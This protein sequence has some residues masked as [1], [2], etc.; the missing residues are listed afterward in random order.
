[1]AKA[2]GDAGGDRTPVTVVLPDGDRFGVSLT[3]DELSELRTRG[4]AA[5]STF[6]L[7]ASHLLRPAGFLLAAAVTA[8]LIPAIT[9]QW[10]DRP[11]ETELKSSLVTKAGEAAAVAVSNVRFLSSGGTPGA[12]AAS[13]ACAP[14]RTH[15]RA[16]RERCDELSLKRDF[17]TAKVTTETRTDWRRTAASVEAQISTYFPSKQAEWHEYIANVGRFLNIFTTCDDKSADDVGALVRYL[18][19]DPELPQWKPL[20][21][22][23]GDPGCGDFGARGARPYADAIDRLTEG[24]SQRREVLLR[25]LVASDAREFSTTGAELW[26]DTRLVL[27][28]AALVT[29]FY[30]FVLAR[31]LRP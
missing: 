31:L 11:K 23:P 14:E 28:V 18:G 25:S 26:R 16:G 4:T 5:P 22:E 6:R 29:L 10:S 13:E 20:L 2:G 17:E 24:L 27:L 7:V 1:M 12:F 19:S 15:S 3:A 21:L 9:K 30:V 8:L